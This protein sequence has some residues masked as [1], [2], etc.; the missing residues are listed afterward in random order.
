MSA[1]SLG[2]DGGYGGINI[3]EKLADLTEKNV[4][5]SAE[6]IKKMIK[7]TT[8]I[9]WLTL[10]ISVFTAI[11]ILP[12]FNFKKENII[13]TFSLW[14]LIL[15]GGLGLSF[16]GLVLMVQSKFYKLSDGTQGESVGGAGR[17]CWLKFGWGLTIGGFVLQVLGTLM[18]P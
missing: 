3:I 14:K 18:A 1:D 12:Y 4:N 7:L 10:I 2:N 17:P 9:F 11:Q 5:A 15:L 13:F 6:V 16:A 8:W